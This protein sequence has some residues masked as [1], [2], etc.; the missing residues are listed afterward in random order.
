MFK[1]TSHLAFN[2]LPRVLEKLPERSP[3][4]TQRLAVILVSHS[5]P[6]DSW[7][8]PEVRQI[9]QNILNDPEERFDALEIVVDHVLKGVIKPLF[10]ASGSLSVAQRQITSDG[11][12]ALRPS[13]KRAP[14][15]GERAPPWRHEHPETTTLL[16]WAVR[17]LGTSQIEP[18]WHLLVPPILTLL[19]DHYP[20]SKTRGCNILTTLLGR[21]DEQPLLRGGQSLL[22]RTGL[23][24]VIWDAVTPCLLLLPPLTP[25]SH[26]IPLLRATYPALLALSHCM[27]AGKP[28]RKARAKLLDKVIRDGILRGMQYGGE[29]AKV[30][31]TLM[32]LL[33]TV[34]DQMEIW[35]ARHLKELVPMISNV[36]SSPFGTTYI[37]LLTS[38]ANALKS[39]LRTCW[40]RISPWVAEM[41]RGL[42]ACWNRIGE[43]ETEKGAEF[44][45]RE[46]VVGIK[47]DLREVVMMLR[48]AVEGDEEGAG[49]SMEALKGEITSV[50]RRLAS[51]FDL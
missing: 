45:E 17:A 9:A 14:A 28:T 51:L 13:T 31:T 24:P 10:S 33:A 41:L 30:A 12:I 26:S 23:G 35:T 22:T 8:T 44:K 5:D 39:I 15:L 43:E 6:S 7:T 29:N 19:D 40:V 50:D 1:E 3:E 2:I 48:K 47:R 32:E 38:A 4:L 27:T 49:E 42:C 25:Q 16:H 46:S 11:R 36:L 18:S 34:V 21:L 20:P 37:P